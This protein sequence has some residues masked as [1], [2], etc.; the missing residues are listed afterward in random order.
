MLALAD[1]TVSRKENL[2]RFQIDTYRQYDILRMYKNYGRKGNEK[3]VKTIYDD[4]YNA[5]VCKL[6]TGEIVRKKQA[7][8]LKRCVDISLSR[9]RRVV[10]EIVM[11]N[12]WAFFGTLTFNNEMQDRTDDSAVFGQFNKWRKA[13]R[14][15]FPNMFYMLVPERHKD[16]CIHFHILVGGVSFK[17]LGLVDSG[18][19]D[20]KGRTIYNSTV[21]KYGFSNLTCVEDTE[22]VSGYIL[23]YIGKDLGVSEENKKRY[24]S[25]RNCERPRCKFIDIVADDEEDDNV[26]KIFE[27]F[28]ER[29]IGMS[30]MFWHKKKNTLVVRDNAVILRRLKLPFKYAYTETIWQDRQIS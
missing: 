8:E 9:T 20:K 17:E 25:S 22:R 4:D 5:W 19:R 12:E 6:D 3:K 7:F 23:K 2:Y 14:R 30:V 11:S 1:T 18:H 21:W 10:R 26:M 16:G 24:W 13:V 27:K 29:S 15:K 28:V